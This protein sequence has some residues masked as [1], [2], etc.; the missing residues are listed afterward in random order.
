MREAGD[1]ALARSRLS[2]DENG[3]HPA[4]GMRSRQ[5]PLHVLAHRLDGRALAKELFKARHRA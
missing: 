5:E 1:Q 3:G 2:L 4:A